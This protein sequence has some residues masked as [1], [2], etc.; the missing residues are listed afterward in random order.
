RYMQRGE[1]SFDQGKDEDASVNLRK[2][3]QKDANLGEAYYKLAQTYLKLNDR[4]NAYQNYLRAVDLLPDT[5]EVKVRFADL[6]GQLYQCD[7]RRPKVLYD[8]FAKVVGQLAAK[9]PNG[10][11]ALRFEGYQALFDR[12]L[13][14]GIALLEKANQV[15]PYEPEVVVPLMASLNQA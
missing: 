1:Q 5:T 11:D 4:R 3:I 6:V 7:A 12:K 15:K 14:Q 2:A 8:Q 9:D 10:Y 13:D